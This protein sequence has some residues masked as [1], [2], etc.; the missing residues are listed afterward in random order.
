MG[1]R[2]WRWQWHCAG[3]RAPL[4][5]GR[6]RR[7]QR[8]LV[9]GATAWPCQGC[10]RQTS[11]CRG[12]SVPPLHM[13]KTCPSSSQLS[14][15]RLQMV[16]AWYTGLP[17]TLACLVQTGWRW[18][19]EPPIILMLL[20]DCAFPLTPPIFSAECAISSPVCQRLPGP[21]HSHPQLVVYNPSPWQANCACSPS[22]RCCPPRAFC[23]TRE[24]RTE[25][26]GAR[27]M[28]LVKAPATP[29][30]RMRGSLP[31]TPPR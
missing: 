18:E 20:V 25:S 26:P 12:W 5:G 10:L 29:T 17:G 27:R 16:G 22:W 23:A 3:C 31:A 28:L 11:T 6:P 30:C 2:R 24:C 9:R 4:V 21:C 13:C 7:C 14:G 1:G 8:Q 15:L 19:K